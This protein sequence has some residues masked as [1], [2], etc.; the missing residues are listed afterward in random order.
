MYP[1]SSQYGGG[2]HQG[3]RDL[4]AL[5]SDNW[6][7]GDKTP[8]SNPKEEGHSYVLNTASKKFHEPNCSGASKIGAENRQEY[9]G[10]REDLLSQGYE[11]CGIC[12]P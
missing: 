1:S 4:C 10:S 6:L 12:K 9:T 11:A 5:P 7:A 8:S 2:L 3:D